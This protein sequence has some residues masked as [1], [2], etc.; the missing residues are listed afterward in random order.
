VVLLKTYVEPASEAG[1]V[2]LDHSYFEK[3]CICI[4]LFIKLFNSHRRRISSPG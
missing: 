3:N 4:V 1:N 2:T